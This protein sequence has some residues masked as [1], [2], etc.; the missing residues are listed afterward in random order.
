MSDTDTT[1]DEGVTAEQPGELSPG[2]LDATNVAEGGEGEEQERP[3]S[4]REQAMAAIVERRA[5][6]FSEEAGSE[7]EVKPPAG[8]TLTLMGEDGSDI[9]I[10]AHARM[11]VKVDGQERDVALEDVMKGVQKYEA[12]DKRLREAS[13]RMKQLSEYEASLKLLAT[14][15]VNDSTEKPSGVPH[16]DVRERA[17]KLLETIYEGADDESA[18]DAVTAILQP[19]VT[20]AAHADTRTVEEIKADLK[21]E[22]R[23]ESAKEKFAEQYADLDK[24]PQLRSLVN[25]RTKILMRE[26]PGATPWTI[27]KEASEDVKKWRDENLG[28]K[29]PAAPTPRSTISPPRAASGRVPL[30]SDSKPK[31]RRETLNEIRISRGQPPI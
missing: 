8:P 16:E 30:G 20:P 24:D 15:T 25:D 9:V 26:K 10:P 13:D 23:V 17:K 19:G 29:K 6:S 12:G 1:Q 31:T 21:H 27:L 2:T 11:R 14:R 18:I 5:K 3:L 22:L 4:A 7:E 28:D